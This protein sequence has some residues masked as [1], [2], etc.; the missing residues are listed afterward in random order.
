MFDYSRKTGPSRIWPAWFGLA[1]LLLICIPLRGQE[2]FSGTTMGPIRYNVTIAELPDGQS[3]ESIQKVIDET[4][5]RVNQLMSTYIESSDV[6]RFN[7]AAKDQWVDVDA[8]TVQ[9]VSRSIEISKKTN[10]AFDITV[11]P[12]VRRWNFGPGKKQ[13][14]Q[15]P[16]QKEIDQ[17]LKRVG[18]QKIAVRKDPPALMKKVDGLEIDLSAIAKGY[19]VDC[20]IRS[21]VELKCESLLVEVGGEVASLG[22]K[23]ESTPW[24]VGIRNPKPSSEKP[25]IVRVKLKNKAMATSGD[26]ENFFVVDGKRFSHTINPSTGWPVTHSLTSSSIVAEDCMTADAFATA[27]LVTGPSSKDAASDWGVE[28]Y[29]LIRKDANGTVTFQKNISVGFPSIGNERP[30]KPGF[31]LVALFS[32]GVFLLAVAG[33]A[34]GVIVANRRIKGSC[35]GIASLQES[36]GESVSCSMCSNPSDQCKEL[37]E[38]VEKK[39]QAS[40][41]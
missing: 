7:R 17:L 18:Y 13:E 2:T 15:L 6:S 36:Q 25:W 23:A 41:A 12:L 30:E 5:E 8:E 16:T 14:F 33:M 38:A 1:L 22:M 9:V 31:N 11:G 26:Y 19:A 10:G 20:V 21:L 27:A 37:R 4:L 39:R 29:N 40:D 34:I 24:I 3:Q 32:V 28:I 35:G